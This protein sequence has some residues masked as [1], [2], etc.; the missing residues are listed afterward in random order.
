[1]LSSPDGA[2]PEIHEVRATKK[3][4]NVQKIDIAR[5]SLI[6]KKRK[7]PEVEKR[8]KSTKAL[9]G[10]V[11]RLGIM[12]NPLLSLRISENLDQK[13]MRHTVYKDV[14]SALIPVFHFCSQ[15]FWPHSRYAFIFCRERK[16]IFFSPLSKLTSKASKK[17]DVGTFF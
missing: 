15:L 11:F 1:M 12:F 6:V 5:A 3:P 2:L 10:G 4:S 7:S 14:V 17:Y 16:R 8:R 9:R 13:F